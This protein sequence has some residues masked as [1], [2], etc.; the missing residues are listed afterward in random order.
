MS[1]NANEALVE[2]TA[3]STV[4]DNV[5]TDTTQD[6]ETEQDAAPETKKKAKKARKSPEDTFARLKTEPATDYVK[7]HKQLLFS[8]LEYERRHHRLKELMQQKEMDVLIV[9]DPINIHYLT[10]FET[11]GYPFLQP[12]VI[13]LDTEPFMMTRY[14]ESYNLHAQTCVSDNYVYSDD[15]NPLE[16]FCKILSLRNLDNKTIGIEKQTFFL[17]R[18]FQAAISLINHEVN[19]VDGSDLVE[20][21]RLVK[22]HEE[23]SLMQEVAKIAETAIAAGIE[24]TA[25]GITENDISA[26]IHQAMY[27]AGGHH[28]ACPPRITSGYRCL[29]GNSTWSQKNIDANECVHIEVAGCLNRY[30]TAITRTLFTGEPPQSLLDAER[31]LLEAL[32][33]AH[34]IIKPGVLASDVDAAIRDAISQL[35]P[36]G[37]KIQ[38]RSGY[39]IGIASAPGLDE[40]QAL[41]LHKNNQRKLKENMTLHIT[42]RIDNIDGKMSIAI[43]DT[44]HVTKSGV[45]SFFAL[46]KGIIRK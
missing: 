9:T 5:E 3:E 21:L 35:N 1:D 4:E 20:K 8:E 16:V 27:A 7:E 39:S 26:N 29:L 28:P 18:H 11:T 36:K 2:E 40:S 38:S 31:V 37:G 42:P 17:P 32:Q 22:S 30:H 24:A 15:E 33:A 25:T 6:N 19:L 10:G 13:T 45:K 23:I 46:D 14:S 12:L 43:S 41:S 44:V 34:N